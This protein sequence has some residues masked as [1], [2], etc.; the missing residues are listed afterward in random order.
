MSWISEALV[1]QIDPQK[2]VTAIQAADDDSAASAGTRNIADP[3]A[4]RS[5]I[6]Q[7]AR[8]GRHQVPERRCGARPAMALRGSRSG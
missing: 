4:N 7:A 6:H 3:A 8:S 2:K 5:A 1:K